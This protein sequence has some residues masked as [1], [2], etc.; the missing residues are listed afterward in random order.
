MSYKALESYKGI[1][2]LPMNKA[3]TVFQRR[4]FKSANP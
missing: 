2:S 1:T 3:E 4:V